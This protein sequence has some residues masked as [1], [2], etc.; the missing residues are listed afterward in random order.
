MPPPATTGSKNQ[1][2]REPSW[3]IIVAAPLRVPEHGA[4]PAAGQNVTDNPNLAELTLLLAGPKH[5]AGLP[6]RLDHAVAVA[7]RRGHRLLDHD[8]KPC[9][10]RLQDQVGVRAVRR[11]DDRH[12]DIAE[13]S[14]HV[15][16]GPA[17]GRG[18]ERRS[19]RTV[20]VGDPTTVMADRRVS[21]TRRH[22]TVPLAKPLILYVDYRICRIERVGIGCTDGC[23]RAG[24]ADQPR[25]PPCSPPA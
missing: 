8:G 22:S 5:H 21:T 6:G 25:T 18:G 11:G 4:E 15:R 24:H 3:P 14:G 10:H 13:Q 1:A 9:I 7:C 2:G 20:D 12:V 16:V 23:H 17:T 19:P